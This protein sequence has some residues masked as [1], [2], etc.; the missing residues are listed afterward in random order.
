M[1]E[2]RL[3]PF[4][5]TDELGRGGMGVVYRAIYTKNGR[6]VAL[7]V[8]PPDLSK[9]E[10]LSARFERELE[11]LKKLRHKNIVQYLGSGKIANQQF[12]AMELVEG[13]SLSTLLKD[14]GRFSW[15]EAIRY[16]MQICDA[17][18][19]AH[20]RGI[21]HRDLK[22]AN[23]MLGTDGT[24][25]LADFGIARDVG[26]TGLTATGRTVGTCEY[27][28]PEQIRGNP[29]VSH[30]TDLYALGCVLFELLTGHRPFEAESLP[31][32]FYKHFEAA[33]PK[34]TAEVAD[35]PVWLEKIILHLMEKDPEKRPWDAAAVGQS[36]KDVETKV[37]QQATIP[38]AHG[39]TGV[40]MTMGGGESAKTTLR[41]QRKKR[42]ESE[43]PFYE[44]LWFLVGCLALILAIVAW[45][46][47]PLNEEQ[48]FARASVIM[49]GNDPLKW[50]GALN[51]YLLPL[52][53]K[54]PQGQYATKVQ[55]YIDR[56]DMAKAEKRIEFSRKLGREP[57]SE[58]ESLYIQAHR[59]EEFGDRVTAADKYNSLVHLLKEKEDARPYV[60]LAR[61]QLASFEGSS[62]KGGDRLK[63]VD[64]ALTKADK[65][66]VDGKALEARKIWQSIVTLYES[67]EEMRPQVERAMSRLKES[68]GN[69]TRG[70][71]LLDRLK[72]SGS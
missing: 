51:D 29:P 53:K 67:N 12:Y 18:D 70:P 7:K 13:G 42:K 21:I 15:Q 55:D 24:L 25:K 54:Y 4:V 27:M 11:I 17:L 64:E 57:A 62:G 45:S 63:L 52:K 59:Y 58:A 49:E 33:P 71:S 48:L 9:D 32:V 31:Q 2:R 1:S 44:R 19:C 61:R 40:P 37:A 68:A 3:G 28:A 66:F 6:E 36:L 38:H 22:P 5:L 10:K 60:N 26:A 20:E 8:L 72:S 23:L 56:I 46:L 14:K 39:A 50:D 69:E 30:K 41:K 34:V 16:G 35:C 43:V 47:W 65:L